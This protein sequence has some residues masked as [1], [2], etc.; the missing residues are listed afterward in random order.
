MVSC[1]PNQQTDLIAVNEWRYDVAPAITLLGGEAHQNEPQQGR[2]QRGIRIG[3]MLNGLLQ[4]QAVGGVARQMNGPRAFLLASPA[5][6]LTRFQVTGDTPIRYASVHIDPEESG[7]PAA[8][9]EP[10]IATLEPLLSGNVH[11]ESKPG[12]PCLCSLAN[13]VL[14]CPLHG[15]M[16]TL[17]LTGK[18]FEIAAVGLNYLLGSNLGSVPKILS[19][20]LKRLHDARA[21]LL[22]RIDDPPSLPVL[23][24]EV[25]M[26]IR[27]L[28]AGFKTQFGATPFAFV[29]EQRMLAAYQM[30]T[31]GQFN[32]A[33]AADHVGYGAPHF[34]TIF[35]KRFG[36]SP[37]QL[38]S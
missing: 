4:T 10:L 5:E 21:I 38:R 2:I 29:H 31:S 3:V 37:S 14:T 33:Q 7:T 13:Q 36:L 32:V 22:S 20:D 16:R 9:I 30:L 19:P 8:Q 18:A 25:G 15:P 27:K 6:W 35:K 26:N 17:F 34:T 24:R 28:S 23:A 11:V 12:I 1:N